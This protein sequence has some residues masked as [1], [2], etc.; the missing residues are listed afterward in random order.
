[1]SNTTG[2]GEPRQYG[3]ADELGLR[4][5]DEA[6]VECHGYETVHQRSLSLTEQLLTVEEQHDLCLARAGR[7]LSD[8]LDWTEAYVD[9][10]RQMVSR[11]KNHPGIVTRSL[12]NE[13]FQGR[14]FQ[15]MYDWVKAHD[16][17]RPVH[18]EADVDARIAD[19]ISTMYPPL[20]KMES[21][22]GTWDGKK[23]MLLCQFMHTM[24]NDPVNIKDYIDLFYAHSCL[25]RR[26]GYYGYGGSFSETH[27]DGY[28]IM[29]GVL[30]SEHRPGPA[31]DEYKKH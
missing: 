5:T 28:F 10:A 19:I 3:L 23:P 20:H 9:R 21:F 17:T 30:T 2:L 15:A 6:D 27:H 18:K 31:L 29:D 26:L 25:T 14:N 11:D 1:M 8:T 22:V 13:A 7:W 16:D 4:I 24:G 12:G